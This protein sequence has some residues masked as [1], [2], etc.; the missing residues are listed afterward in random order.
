M[1]LNAIWYLNLWERKKIPTVGGVPSPSLPRSVASLPRLRP[2]SPLPL[3][4]SWK[5]IDTYDVYKNYK[6]HGM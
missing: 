3:P 1:L 4:P 6:V 2:Q 5:Q